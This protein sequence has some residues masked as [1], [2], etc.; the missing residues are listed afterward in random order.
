MLPFGVDGGFVFTQSYKNYLN[1]YKQL[2]STTNELDISF[3]VLQEKTEIVTKVL[4]N[5]QF[6]HFR[7]EQIFP[8]E[9]IEILYP[10]DMTTG[11]IHK[12]ETLKTVSLVKR[13][14]NING[15]VFIVVGSNENFSKDEKL[16]AVF[17]S[18]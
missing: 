17:H 11:I 10:T 3:T 18:R 2:F 15:Q 16:N 1:K 8:D 7:I 13:N 12:N 5:R 9:K 6:V 4:G 14:P